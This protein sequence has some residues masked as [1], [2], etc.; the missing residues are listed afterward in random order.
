MLLFPMRYRNM[1]LI[2]RKLIV[3]AFLSVRNILFYNQ[4]L[5]LGKY[6]MICF[7]LATKNVKIN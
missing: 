3:M 4:R 5:K 7:C 1:Y 6:V 2:I